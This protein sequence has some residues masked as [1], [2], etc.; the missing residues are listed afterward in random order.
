MIEYERDKI[1]R[2]E[3]DGWA[4]MTPEEE[5]AFRLQTA[6]GELT[7]AVFIAPNA[8]GWGVFWSFSP[9]DG[10]DEIARVLYSQNR[11]L[12]GAAGAAHF[13][14]FSLGYES[15]ESNELAIRLAMAAIELRE[16]RDDALVAAQDSTEAKSAAANQRAYEEGEYF[17]IQAELTREREEQAESR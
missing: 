14:I 13:E 8:D 17:R 16:H 15:G 4:A 1:Y 11:S 9:N 7:Q 5:G 2:P 10:G 12:I 6:K 3:G